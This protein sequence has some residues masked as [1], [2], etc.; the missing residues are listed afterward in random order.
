[1]KN[2]IFIIVLLF[3]NYVSAQEKILISENNNIKLY[4]SQASINSDG[5]IFPTIYKNG[6]IYSSKGKLDNY[7]LFFTDDKLASKKIKIGASYALGALSIYN[8]EVYFTGVAKRIGK[9]YSY[10]FTVVKGVID[11][12]KIK[13]NRP[14]NICNK[15]FSYT[16]PSISKDGKKMIVV[17]N[18]Q[19]S[20]H[21]L[22][23]VRNDKNE[24]EKGD[25]IFICQPDY[26]IINPIYYNKN[27]IYFSSNL[28]KEGAIRSLFVNKN[29]K[30][31]LEGI[32]KETGDFNIYK[33]E[34][35]NGI[36]GIPQKADSFNSEFDDLGVIF[37]DEKSG[38]LTT[39]RYNDSENIYY[40]ELK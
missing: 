22:E 10:N 4:E 13:Q 21:L 30:I 2:R 14:L 23:F 18:E 25:V 26:E 5:N 17:T 39:Y 11:G 32:T 36:W 12:L 33:L 9:N 8:N 16:Y 20:L 37:K 19:E 6:L 1:M 7:K 3:L 38:Y 35:E 27:T 28:N 24:W 29:D 31:Y 34:R 15:D 40:F